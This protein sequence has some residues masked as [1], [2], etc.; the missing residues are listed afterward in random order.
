MQRLQD[1]CFPVNITTFVTV[2]YRTPLVAA[3]AKPK[4]RFLRKAKSHINHKVSEKCEFQVIFLTFMII[5]NYKLFHK[6][7]KLHL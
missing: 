2:F 1:R 5:V 3:S 7:Q 6:N 4:S